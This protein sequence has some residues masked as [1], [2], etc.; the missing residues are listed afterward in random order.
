MATSSDTTP[1]DVLAIAAEIIKLL[2][3]PLK[4][5]SKEQVAQLK[6]NSAKV[7]EV[8]ARMLGGEEPVINHG[9]GSRHQQVIN[10]T[11]LN[12]RPNL[13]FEVM[14]V[15]MGGH[16][17][18]FVVNIAIRELGSQIWE[19][20]LS[21][22]LNWLGERGEE[23]VSVKELHTGCSIREL[24]DSVQSSLISE[25][26][27]LVF[28]KY[29]NDGLYMLCAHLNW[30]NWQCADYFRAEGLKPLLEET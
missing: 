20:K 28:S 15:A 14:A 6:R 8:F 1:G 4:R 11:G 9:R 18:T 19:H 24:R 26:L 30:S 23:F 10:K 27:N 2:T 22:S 13:Y 7:Q 3:P 12:F 29:D 25:R 5:A 21:K 16:P 17:D